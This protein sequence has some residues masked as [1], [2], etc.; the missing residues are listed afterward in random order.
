MHNRVRMGVASFLTKDLHIDWRRGAQHFMDQLIDGDV[1]SNTHGWQ[2]T[3]GTG[4]DPSPYFRVFNPITQGEKFD[5]DGDYI[6]R[7][8]PELVGV[9]GRAVHRP[10]G[11]LAAAGYP[12]PIVDHGTER[13]EALRRHGSFTRGR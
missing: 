8:V 7:W 1:A 4:T 12:E 10:H 5:P 9:E 13:A 11:T 3:A 2:W 6:R